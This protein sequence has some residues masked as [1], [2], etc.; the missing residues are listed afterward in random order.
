MAPAT[1]GPFTVERS[2][3][4]AR[5]AVVAK[6]MA[7]APREATAVVCPAVVQPTFPKGPVP[8]PAVVEERTGV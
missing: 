3:A 8:E 1:T 6:V 7:P 2:E 4:H 5:A